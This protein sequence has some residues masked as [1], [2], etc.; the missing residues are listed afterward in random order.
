MQ[1]YGA[2]PTNYVASY[3]QPQDGM[4]ATQSYVG[5]PYSQGYSQ[6]YTV[7]A[8]QYPGYS[9]A[10]N[11]VTDTQ[12]ASSV[13]PIQDPPYI[14]DN[15]YQQPTTKTYAPPPSRSTRTPGYVSPYSTT[16]ASYTATGPATTTTYTYSGPTTTSY[17]TTSGYTTTTTYTQPATTTYAQPI[18]TTTYTQPVAA[19]YTQPVTTTHSTAPVTTAA[20]VPPQPVYTTAAVTAAPMSANSIQLVPA[21]DVPPGN[22]PNDA[23]PSQWFEIV[24]PGNGPIRIGRVNSTCVCVGVRVPNRYIAAGERALIEARILSRPPAN[25]LTYGIY[26]NVLEPQ[27][28]M[29]DTDVTIR[30]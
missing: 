30:L 8:V 12:F 22:R 1:N 21:L 16:T 2:P 13:V 23:A 5:Q 7:T 14:V 15:V 19:T 3:N 11:S 20:Y 10:V 29:L 18:T 27:N 4:Y 24:R 17:G 25:N 28:V 26:V 9:S 6:P